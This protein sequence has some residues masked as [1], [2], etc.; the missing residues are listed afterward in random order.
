MSCDRALHPIGTI[1]PVKAIYRGNDKEGNL[2]IL[3]TKLNLIGTFHAMRFI[4]AKLRKIQA[5]KKQRALKEMLTKGNGSMSSPKAEKFLR[6][7]C[8]HK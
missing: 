7:L 3:T 4:F 6:L 2:Y 8:D 1:V 5:K